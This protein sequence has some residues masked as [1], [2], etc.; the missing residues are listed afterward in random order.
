[1]CRARECRVTLPDVATNFWIHGGMQARPNGTICRNVVMDTW[2]RKSGTN[3]VQ[4]NA[5]RRLD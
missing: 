2:M 4:C 1:M 5:R 3:L